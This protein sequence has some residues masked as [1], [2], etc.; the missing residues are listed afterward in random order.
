MAAGWRFSMSLNNAVYFLG[1]WPL[2]YTLLTLKYGVKY[3][4]VYINQMC[5]LIFHSNK[6]RHFCI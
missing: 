3:Q 5:T 4:L 2:T 1:L 6:N